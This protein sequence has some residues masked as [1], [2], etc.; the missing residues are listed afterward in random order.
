MPCARRR[1][2][3]YFAL[4]PSDFVSPQGGPRVH[5]RVFKTKATQTTRRLICKVALVLERSVIA[6]APGSLKGQAQT[7]ALKTLCQT[8]A[9]SSTGKADIT[10][11]LV[12]KVVTTLRNIIIQ[13]L[14]ATGVFVL[15]GLVRFVLADVKARS[16]EYVN[17]FGRTV[18]MKAK[19]PH[20]RVYGHVPRRY[21][22]IK[23]SARRLN[24]NYCYPFR[25][26]PPWY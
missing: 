19:G 22:N 21:S 5:G 24:A 23:M 4:L 1:I 3:G 8:L 10:S 7:H 18:C 20:R 9:T 2:S 12:A 26:Y 15:D 13:D 6:A 14:R 17:C 16:A 11:D 25:N